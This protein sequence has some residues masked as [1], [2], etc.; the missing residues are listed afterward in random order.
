MMA[1]V[2]HPGSD[3]D[4]GLS[5]ETATSVSMHPGSDIGVSISIDNAG[6]KTFT[7]FQGE[8]QLVLTTYGILSI[9]VSPVEPPANVGDVGTRTISVDPEFAFTF[10][11][12]GRPT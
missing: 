5:A 9:F 1:D 6:A 2:F 10:D 11:R 12:F 8:A 4:I 3:I 7:S